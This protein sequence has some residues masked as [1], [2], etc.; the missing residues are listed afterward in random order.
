MHGL[1]P[2]ARKAVPG[3][4]VPPGAVEGAVREARELAEEVEN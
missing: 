3:G 4:R 1:I 2:V